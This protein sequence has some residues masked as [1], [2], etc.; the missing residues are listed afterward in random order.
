MESESLW[1]SGRI[2]LKLENQN[3]DIEFRNMVFI[4]IKIE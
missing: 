4:S 3:Y 1:Y 2:L